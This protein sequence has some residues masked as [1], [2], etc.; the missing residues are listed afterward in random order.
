MTE[1]QPLGLLERARQPAVPAE[2][3]GHVLALRATSAAEVVPVLRRLAYSADLFEVRGDVLVGA[4]ALGTEPVPAYV[5]AQLDDMRAATDRPFIFSLRTVAQGGFLP[6][7]SPA[8]VAL[9]QT[10][11]DAGVAY[12]EIGVD[13]WP[14]DVVA[15]VAAY[16]AARKTSVIGSVYDSTSLTWD[17]PALVSTLLAAEQH[18]DLFKVTL[19]ADDLEFER[20]LSS[21]APPG[22]VTKPVIKVMT[23]AAESFAQL[24]APVSWISHELLP[25][26]VRDPFSEPMTLRQLNAAR[27]LAGLIRPMRFYVIGHNISYTMSP[28]IHNAAFREL[29]LPYTY[30]IFDTPDIKNVVDLIGRADFGGASVTV[31][32]KVALMPL[33]DRLSDSVTLIGASNTVVVSRPEADTPPTLTGDNTD[34]LGIKGCIEGVWPEAGTCR[35]G[36]IIGAGGAA[37]ASV[38]ALYRL[39]V[40]T[41]YIVNRTV[42]KCEQIRDEFVDKVAVVVL[43]SLHNLPA[44]FVPVEIIIG[45]VPANTCAVADFPPAVFAAPNGGV[46]VEMAYKPPVTPLIQASRQAPGWKVVNGI[47]ILLEQAYSQFTLW[48]Q[49]RA[50]REVMIKAIR[51]HMAANDM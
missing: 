13:C 26:A 10:A 5:R 39:G 22:N 20:V 27:A 25:T 9:Y 35:A 15:A 42:S 47:D 17:S 48:T 3:A 44:D 6:D 36:L 31:P 1:V 11:V 18:V 14:L 45:N 38:Y 32:H 23:G 19:S 16:A 41:I 24:S 37:R 40:Q 46:L 43:E 7:G 49:R 4:E 29:G 12:V 50:P 51:D 2:S 8:A 30:S 21:F 28:I 33:L 34:W